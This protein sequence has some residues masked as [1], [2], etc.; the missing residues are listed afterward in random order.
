MKQLKQTERLIQLTREKHE[1]KQAKGRDARLNR[2]QSKIVLNA[3][4][5]RSEKTQN[6]VSTKSVMLLKQHQQLLT[7]AK[8]QVESAA[9][10]IL[11]LPNTNF[12]KNKILV[13]FKEVSFCYDKLKP[14]INNFSFVLQGPTRLGI[15]GANGSGKTSLIKLIAGKL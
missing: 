13:K 9:H 10:F 2:S 1:Q 5:S 15:T 14:L 12:S 3:M 7:E 6:K 8:E 4:Q 11:Q